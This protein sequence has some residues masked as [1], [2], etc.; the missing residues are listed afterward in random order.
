MNIFRKAVLRGMKESPA[1]TVVTIIGVVLSTAMVTAVSAFVVS[2]QKYMVDNAAVKY[3]Q[4]HVGFSDVDAQSVLQLTQDERA[5]GA[6]VYENIG[7]AVLEGGKNQ[8]KP[9]LFVAGFDGDTFDTL[10]VKLISGRLPG[11]DGEVL[12][13]AHVAANGGVKISV[14]DTLTLAL[15]DRMADGGKLNQHNPYLSGEEEGTGQEVFVPR[16]QKAYTVVGI[17]ARPS[18]E[19]Y[20]APGYTLITLGDG[21]EAAG[22][23]SVYVTLAQPY[24]LHSYLKS[25]AKEAGGAP[26]YA[27]NDDVLRFMGLSGDQMF[28][29]LLFT[30]GGILVV[31]IMLGSVFLIHNSFTIALNDR[32]RQFGIF[33]SVGA[34]ERQLRHSVLFEGFC[35]GMAG[36]PAG[37]LAGIPAIR[38]VL[39]LVEKNFSNLFYDTVP[40]ALHISVSAI[41]AAAAVSLITILISAYLPARKAAAVPVMECIRQTNEV[42]IEPKSVKTSR[43]TEF[44]YGYEGT[45]ALKNFKRNRKR[46]RSIVLSLVLS[47]VLFVSADTFGAYLKEAAGQSVVD[48]EWDIS[49]YAQEIDADEMFGLY[50]QLKAAEGVYE[51]SW[52]MI[53]ECACEIK[54]EKLTE[55]FRASAGFSP[56]SRTAELSLE[57]VYLPD[58]VFLDLAESFGLSAGEYTGQDARLPA[59]AVGQDGEEAFG[60]FEGE[61]AGCTVRGRSGWAERIELTFVD[62]LPVEMFSG[63]VSAEKPYMFLAAAPYRMRQALEVSDVPA[64]AVLNFRSRNPSQSAGEMETMLRGAGITFQYSLY[65]YSEVFEEGRNIIFI[66]DLFSIVF[67][68]MISL[69]ATANVFNTISTNIRL[70]R[71]EL[72]MLRS[73]GMADRSFNRMMRYECALYGVKTLILG[74]P[75]SVLVSWLIYWQMSAGGADMRFLFPWASAGIS[76]LGVFLVIFITMLYAVSRVRKEN[77]I[78][79]L[80]DDMT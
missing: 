24:Q 26:D 73:M 64:G 14:G 46:Y 68:A 69:I 54:A 50:D 44:L 52:Q 80:R 67:V 59:V 77:I 6:A 45:L 11:D 43:M 17:C 57:L 28:N 38:L 74:I 34:T 35:I 13:P 65:N 63:G 41:A 36:I 53:S 19:E 30:V 70:R 7:Y 23:F 78:D 22:R 61:A 58:S 12:V 72:A 3:G 10:P 71:R 42:R 4:W 49:F 51:S 39:S 79:A 20:T 47:V 16:G 76:V 18:F 66:V 60:I 15:G 5:A 27:L 75:V 33:L 40:L 9:Y 37:I 1:R 56:K 62:V 55:R 48:S 21:A 25:I 31:L 32:M 8:Y 29:T 2:L